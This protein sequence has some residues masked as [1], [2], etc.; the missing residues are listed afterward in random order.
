MTDWD[1]VMDQYESI[2]SG[3]YCNMLDKSCVRDVAEQIG[4]DELVAVI[5]DGNYAECLER[6]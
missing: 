2:R 5:D 6:Y 4:F 3:G 1:A